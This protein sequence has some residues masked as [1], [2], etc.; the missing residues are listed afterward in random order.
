[1]TSD[2]IPGQERIP[3]RVWKI[4][5]VLIY[6]MPFQGI[7]AREVLGARINEARQ[8]DAAMIFSHFVSAHVTR[9]FAPLSAR[10]ALDTSAGRA[11]GRARFRQWRTS[12][13][14]RRP[15]GEIFIIIV[16]LASL[17]RVSL[18]WTR[19]SLSST[20]RL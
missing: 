10:L 11:C 2:S 19:G 17:T 12:L 7:I 5:A 8:P 15:V 16:K 1:M 20:E 4:P 3:L 13:L 14:G 6:Q 9:I 18:R